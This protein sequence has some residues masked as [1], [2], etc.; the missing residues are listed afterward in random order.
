MPSGKTRS[1][2]SAFASHNT[3]NPQLW[4]EWPH[5]SLEHLLPLPSAATQIV[6]S[7]TPFAL[8]S[9]PHFRNLAAAPRKTHT[10]TEIAIRATT[11]RD[12]RIQNA[13][14]SPIPQLL[15]CLSGLLYPSVQPGAPTALLG[16]AYLTPHLQEFT[17]KP[18][19]F[20]QSF[21]PSLVLRFFG[22][23]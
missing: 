13:C 8:R 11:N 7:T 23:N 20:P 16:N 17:C 5:E 6:P 9:M 18:S 1:N 21:S 10:I 4:I 19:N 14:P 2:L 22:L 12:G 3:R 15:R